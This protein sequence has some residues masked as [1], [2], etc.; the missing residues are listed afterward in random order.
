MVR[1]QRC[2]S[3]AL[4]STTGWLMLV[5]AAYEHDLKDRG[6]AVAV[7]RTIDAMPQLTTSRVPVGFAEATAPANGIS[8][9]YVRGGTGP[10][11]VLLHGYPHRSLVALRSSLR[12]ICGVG[13]GV[14]S[15]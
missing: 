13:C 8:M 10:T 1:R 9:N 15:A 7:E 14:G 3:C 12:A 4:S 6:P 2:R 11:L 5:G